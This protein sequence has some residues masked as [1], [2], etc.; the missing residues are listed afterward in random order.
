MIPSP[1]DLLRVL[2]SGLRPDG[3]AAVTQPKS[4]KDFAAM[5]AQ[6]RDG[7]LETGLPV[8]VAEGSGVELDAAQ[9]ERLGRVVDRAHAEGATR[10]AV[11]MD[12][13]TFDVDVLSRRVLGEADLSE[14]RVLTGIDGFV[15][16]GDGEDELQPM[17][18]MPNAG[19]V[20][21]SLLKLLSGGTQDAA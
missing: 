2:G 16:L 11:M 17:L 21:A 18:P 6:A 13:A 1:M 4:V 7:G 5:L 14:G 8:T 19:A 10:I 12:G 20:D 9:L 15:R 3:S